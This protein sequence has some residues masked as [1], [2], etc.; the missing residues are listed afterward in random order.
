MVA[1]AVMRIPALS[2]E[3]SRVLRGYFP[4]FLHGSTT[5]TLDAQHTAMSNDCAKVI[6]LHELSKFI[7]TPSGR[8]C[9]SLKVDMASF[10]QDNIRNSDTVARAPHAFQPFPAELFAYSGPSLARFR[11]WR[12]FQELQGMARH[13]CTFP[14]YSTK[15][16]T[17]S[18]PSALRRSTLDLQSL[19]TFQPRELPTCP[20]AESYEHA[21]SIG[22]GVGAAKTFSV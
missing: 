14:K 5:T 12:V 6:L 16:I 19:S 10:P 13:K 18:V 4:R 8:I 15:D 21:N 20:K 7:D 3:L 11:C 1:L 22:T 9:W 2:V 17:W